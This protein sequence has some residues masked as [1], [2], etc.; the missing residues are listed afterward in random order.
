MDTIPHLTQGEYTMIQGTESSTKLTGV[1]LS[2]KLR[3]ALE[4]IVEQR[5][6]EDPLLPPPTLSEIM[7]DLIAKEY[8]RI[9]ES[10]TNGRDA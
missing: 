8:R 4:F 1:K 7:R 9:T 5:H 6:Q 10:P 2:K 3:E